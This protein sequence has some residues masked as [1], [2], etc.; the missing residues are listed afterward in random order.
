MKVVLY[1]RVSTRDKEQNPETQVHAMRIFCQN[2]GHEIVEIYAEKAHAQ[3]LKQRTEWRRLMK[4]SL[5]ARP[6]FDA[7]LVYKIDRAWRD[8]FQMLQDLDA[9]GMQGL[10]F[11]STTQDIDTTTA[12]GIFF[13]RVLGL[14]AELELETIRER[15]NAGLDRA[16]ANGVVLGRKPDNSR[17]MK[18]AIWAVENG[19]SQ[20]AA[21]KA[22]GVSK[23]T[24]NRKVKLSQ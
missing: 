9:W 3:N 13:L 12:M 8:A 17:E 15:V 18:L 16:R 14:I 19:Q 2:K 21:A 7:I 5:R 24:L 6:G 4:R 20:A 10:F 22:F 23:S 11:I 1:A